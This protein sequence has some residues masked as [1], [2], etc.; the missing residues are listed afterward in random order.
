MARQIAS[1]IALVRSDPHFMRGAIGVA[2]LLFVACVL[3]LIVQGGLE[4][5]PA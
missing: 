4:G 2:G 3:A 5:R 1:A